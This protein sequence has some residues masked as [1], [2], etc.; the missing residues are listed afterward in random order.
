MKKILFSLIVIGVV[1]AIAV[2]STGAF[3]SDAET[4]TGNTFTA[5]TIDLKIDN[6][7]WYNG[8]FQPDL[9]WQLSDLTNNQ[10]F[11]NFKDLKPGDQAEDT[12]SLHVDSNDSWVC[13]N[14]KVTKNDDVSSN[15]PELEAGDVQEDANNNWDGELASALHF[16]FWA[17]DGDNVLETGENILLTGTPADLPQGDG[18]PGMTFP[19]VDSTFNAFGTVGDPMPGLQTKYVGKAWCFGDM[20]VTPLAQ[21]GV[22]NARNPGGP[23]GAGITC[24]GESSTNIT[25]SDSLMGDITFSAVQSRNNPNFVCRPVQTQCSEL[26]TWASSVHAFNQGV[27]KDGGTI[28]PDRSDPADA[29]GVAESTGA[30]YDTVF[31]GTFFSLG[32]NPDVQLGFGGNIELGFPKFIIN[33]PGP[34]IKVFEVTGGTSYP[35]E[36]VK[37]EASQDGTA[38]T[39]LAASVSRDAEVDLGSLAWAKYVRVTDVSNRGDFEATADGYDLDGVKALNCVNEVVN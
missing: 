13:A 36:K 26:D 31:P 3:F 8:V 7:S 20:T 37:V 39:L 17:D 4:S 10:L 32:F 16:V 23:D 28:A 21:D 19:I 27:R 22:N 15:E 33:G 14:V 11:F 30:L 24:S 1:S 12:I 29:L 25:Q 34:D 9:S 38:W 2:S 6:S 5:G 18:N 35:D